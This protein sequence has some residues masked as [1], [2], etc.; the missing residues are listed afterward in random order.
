MTIATYTELVEEMDAW[1]NR[2]DLSDRIPTFIRLFE[3]R[4]NRLLRNPDMECSATQDTVA[5]TETYALPGNF[6]QIRQVY[7]NT[8]PKC[9]LEAMTPQV[10]RNTYTDNT[11]GQPRAYA[12]VGESLILAPTPDAA[13]EMVLSGFE[14]LD[15]LGTGNPTNWLLDDHPDAYLF[16]SL[17]RAD[18]YLKDDSRVAFWK[19]AEDEIVSEAIREANT[20]RLPGT[21]LMM[22]PTV[23]E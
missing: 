13:Y 20:K 21:P 7:L 4:M 6:R 22:Q 15:A 11:S 1:L 8:N 19:S 16:G 5:D 10:L 14:A 23:Y 9:V 18:A 12:V 3:A 17:A 2:A